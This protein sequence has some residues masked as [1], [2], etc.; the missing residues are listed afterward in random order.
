MAAGY[1]RSWPGTNYNKSLLLWNLLTSAHFICSVTDKASGT[2]PRADQWAETHWKIC[3]TLNVKKRGA[4]YEG[5]Q[6]LFAFLLD[7][8]HS[9]REKRCIPNKQQQKWNGQREI[10]RMEL[11][12]LE[13]AKNTGLNSSF[14]VKW[15]LY[16]LKYQNRGFASPWEVNA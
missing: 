4:V 7:E 3:N 10:R 15:V 5:M 13:H 1:A 11:L 16:I 14:L 6:E 9:A 2:K 8:Y 12:S